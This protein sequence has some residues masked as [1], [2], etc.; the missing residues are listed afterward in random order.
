MIRLIFFFLLGTNPQTIMAES[1]IF[2]SVVEMSSDYP[3]DRVSNGD[4][5]IYD[6]NGDGLL[7]VAKKTFGEGGTRNPTF[8][9]FIKH[10]EKG[11]FYFDIGIFPYLRYDHEAA[12]VSSQEWGSN[13]DLEESFYHFYAHRGVLQITLIYSFS[14]S[15]FESNNSSE[16]IAV[17]EHFTG[18]GEHLF[19]EYLF[20]TQ[21]CSFAAASRNESA[22]DSYCVE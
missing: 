12:L 4:I 17:R 18:A 1:L 22:E 10:G 19:T 20:R 3:K 16:I 5:I 8:N 11:N 7:D 6:V 9:Y 21:Q 2:N 15:S 13:A 14:Q